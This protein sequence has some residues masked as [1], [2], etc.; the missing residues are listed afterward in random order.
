[1][2]RLVSEFETL[3]EAEWQRTQVMSYFE[4]GKLTDGSARTH[5]LRTREAV[6]DD[7]LRGQAPMYNRPVYSLK[8]HLTISHELF[9]PSTPPHPQKA[10]PLTLPLNQI[11]KP[12]PMRIDPMST[13]RS[14]LNSRINEAE[15]VAHHLES[16]L[17]DGVIVQSGDEI[18]LR[19]KVLRMCALVI[20]ELSG[21]EEALDYSLDLMLR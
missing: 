5:L 21:V 20:R 11:L 1:M 19:V 17:G 14:P 4:L 9:H 16:N 18:P 6:L 3:L 12:R 13:C 10:N 8:G 15:G 7:R 2:L